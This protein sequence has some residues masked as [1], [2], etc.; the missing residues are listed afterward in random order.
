MNNKTT[1]LLAILLAVCLAAG[2]GFLFGRNKGASLGKQE[3]SKLQEL[4]RQS[5]ERLLVEDGPIYVIGHSSPDSDT[6]CSAI[7][8]ARLLTALGYDAVPAANG[9]PNN[10]T[11]YILKTAGVEAPPVLEDASGK[12]IFLVDHSEYLQSTEGLIDAHIVGIIDHHGIGSVSTGQQVLYDARP[13]GA[14]A[15]IIWLSYLNYGID[16]DKETSLLLLGAVLSD[17]SYLTG[18][19]TAEAD[20]KAIDALAETAGVDD[21]AAFYE[22][23]HREALSYEGMTDME[24][25]FSDYKEYEAGSTKFGIGLLNAI[26]NETAKELAQRMKAVL[27]EGFK[28]RNVD[29]LY[30]SVGIRE[31]GEKIDYIVPCNEYSETVFKAAFPNYDEYDGTAYIFKAGLG[32][33]T[34]FVPGLTDYILS[35]PR[36]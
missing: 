10:E 3:L 22:A 16:L 36:D 5:I 17:T 31:N 11:K 26:D 20:R 30:A 2:G 34:L 9:V 33:K 8:Y 24:I 6:V 4:N 32:R 25:L 7:A 13:I 15:T 21:V 35:V 28:T 19:T 1:K 18:T 27:P 14:T 23:L 12:N 29:L